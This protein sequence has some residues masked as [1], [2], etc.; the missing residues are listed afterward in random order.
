MRFNSVSSLVAALV[1]TLCLMSDGARV[2]GDLDVNVSSCHCA[3]AVSASSVAFKTD[4]HKVFGNSIEENGLS[5]LKRRSDVLFYVEVRR[6]AQGYGDASWKLTRRCDDE[7]CNKKGA[8]LCPDIEVDAD[9]D[10]AVKFLM[11]YSSY[12]QSMARRSL[13]LRPV[14]R[15]GWGI[16][17]LVQGLQA[18]SILQVWQHGGDTDVAIAVYWVALSP[19]REPIEDRMVGWP[20]MPHIEGLLWGFDEIINNLKLAYVWKPNNLEKLRV[21]TLPGMGSMPRSMLVTDK[22]HALLPSQE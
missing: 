22:L 4:T 21:H 20:F 13:A 2:N 12:L 10:A 11:D 5:E 19:T 17:D 6:F 15:K 8:K 7:Y 16:T 3:C 18:P 1:L 9:S 14:P